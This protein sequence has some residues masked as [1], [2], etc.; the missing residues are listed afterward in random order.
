MKVCELIA[1]LQQCEPSATCA[2]VDSVGIY[3]LTGVQQTPD[4]DA[5]FLSHVSTGFEANLGDEHED[6]P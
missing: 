5:V 4:R 6:T 1:M 2:L 3:E